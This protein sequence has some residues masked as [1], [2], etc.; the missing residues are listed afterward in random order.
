MKHPH[1]N[2]VKIFDV[3]DNYVI[4]EHVNVDLTSLSKVELK[5][6]MIKLKEYLQ[7]LG[8]IYIDWKLD[9][10]GIGN[11]NE[12]KLFDFDASGLINNFNWVIE[13][14]HYYAYNHAILDG[15]NTP[16]EIDNY[17]FNK[18]LLKEF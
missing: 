10:I 16:I 5:L 14:E 13:A 4:M 7:N 1:K 3:G 11:D 8:I 17:C 9:N 6:K 15:C 2:I 12:L 18:Y